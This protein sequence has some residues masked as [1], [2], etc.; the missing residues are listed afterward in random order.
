MTGLGTALLAAVTLTNASPS[1]VFLRD[2]EAAVESL[3]AS[4][5]RLTASAEQAAERIWRNPYASIEIPRKPQWGFAEELWE[6]A[7]GLAQ[8]ADGAFDTPDNVIL[9]S[10]GVT[11]PNPLNGKLVVSFP[12]TG[13]DDRVNAVTDIVYGWMWCC[14]YAAALTRRCK[15]F[16]AVTKGLHAA[17]SWIV[18]GCAWSPFNLPRLLPCDEKIAPGRLARDYLGK[19]RGLLRTMDGPATRDAVLRAAGVV[20]AALDGGHQVGIAG[21][22]H[23]IVIECTNE[24]KS[25]M[26]GICAFGNLPEAFSEALN[27]GDTLVWIA[28]DGLDSHWAD[29]ARHIRA[30]QLD[31]VVSYAAWAPP[32]SDGSVKAFIPQF[33][34]GADAEVTIPVPPYA[35]AP[36][37]EISR[38]VILRM[39]DA[40]V[41]ATHP[42]RP[43]DSS[44][45]GKAA[46]MSI[47]FSRKRPAPSGPLEWTEKGFTFV[48]SF[49]RKW[50]LKG[51]TAA[52]YDMLRPL[53]PKLIAYE[54]N[55]RF[56]LMDADGRELTSAKRDLIAPFGLF[57][58]KERDYAVFA[59][60]GLYGRMDPETG[61]TLSGKLSPEYPEEGGLTKQ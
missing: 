34:S 40:E 23:P 58:M 21:L 59:E 24:L 57:G 29:Y 3:E 1:V 5:S 52:E 11:P 18:N 43:D 48:Q 10:S 28:Y 50:A 30:A 53:S 4:I 19:A 44:A 9:L 56:G 17:D 35:M 33:W 38:C 7:G 36:V 16:P 2:T 13:A 25:R 32:P 54:R 47:D 51:K 39:L 37:S 42:R 55:R 41:A 26:K 60:R 6:R 14:E 20:R 45:W 31:L 49:D 12:A 15:R 22:G 46:L 27:P 8:I 61:R